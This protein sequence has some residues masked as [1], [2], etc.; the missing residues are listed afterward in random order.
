M[1]EATSS[2]VLLVIQYTVHNIFLKNILQNT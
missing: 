2:M 1:P